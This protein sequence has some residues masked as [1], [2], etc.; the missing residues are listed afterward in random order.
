MA[1]ALGR[2]EPPTIKIKMKT[3]IT[4]AALLLLGGGALSAGAQTVTAGLNDLVL[5]FYASGGTGAG[6]NL[7][8]DLGNVGNFYGVSGTITLAGLSAAD[9]SSTYGSTWNTRTDLYWGV[10]GT[11]GSTAGTTIGLN[12]IASKTLWGS[13][14]EATLGTLSTPW[15]AGTTFAQQ[16]PANTIATLYTGA[17]GSL[18]GASATGN[19]ATA[20]ILNNTLAGSWSKQLGSTAAAF[21]Y[22]NP[23]GVFSNST[24]ISVGSFAASDLYALQPGSGAAAYVGTFALSSGGA[25]T[26]SNTP[27]SVP[28]PSTYAAILGLVTLG[29]VALR[30]RQQKHLS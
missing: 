21:G 16:G 9:L 10:I 28:E 22:F 5:G 17:G 19:S 13:K 29:F 25:L 7:E 12:S 15:N 2:P 18:N 24:N 1:P 8:V 20:A 3:K 27:S 6:S 14:T 23:S 4:L 11:T 30:R 26:Y